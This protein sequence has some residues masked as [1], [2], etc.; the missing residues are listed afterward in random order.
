MK[1]KKHLKYIPDI[2]YGKV[3]KFVSTS[4]IPRFMYEKSNVISDD[5]KW[6]WETSDL[7]I[8]FLRYYAVPALRTR[9]RRTKYN[10][11]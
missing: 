6:R 2:R 10:K 11:D 4:W 9:K 1:N 8:Y 3:D 5:F 7:R